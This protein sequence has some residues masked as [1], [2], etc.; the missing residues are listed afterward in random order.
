MMKQLS[1]FDA[2]MITTVMFEEKV[3]IIFFDSTTRHIPSTREGTTLETAHWESL[4]NG[5]Y[6]TIYLY[7]YKGSREDI[8]T[9]IIKVNKSCT[10][11]F[12][13]KLNRL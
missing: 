12:F 5:P 3:P 1:N 6:T 13:L 2:V 9:F 4:N 11:R 8:W 7:D 10:M